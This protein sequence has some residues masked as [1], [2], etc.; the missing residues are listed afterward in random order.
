MPAMA[1]KG[2]FPVKC[3]T[4]LSVFH[5]KLSISRPRILPR[6]GGDPRKHLD[7]LRIHELTIHDLLPSL[8][9]QSCC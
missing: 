8:S 9:I 1:V 7:S 2:T 6:G 4:P 5:R 3:S